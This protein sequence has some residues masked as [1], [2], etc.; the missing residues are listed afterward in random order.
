MFAR[1][2]AAIDAELKQTREGLFW[3]QQREEVARLLLE[4]NTMSQQRYGTPIDPGTSQK[5]EQA[6]RETERR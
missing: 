5:Y 1:D 4:N 3:A 6:R 2:R